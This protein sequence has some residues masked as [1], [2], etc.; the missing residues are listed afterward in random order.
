MGGG[1]GGGLGSMLNMPM[2]M[3]NGMGIMGGLNGQPGFMEGLFKQDKN[4]PLPQ[5]GLNSLWKTFGL[6]G[7][8]PAG[9]KAT[10]RDA[11]PIAGQALGT[12][13]LPGFGGGAGK[14]AGTLGA[15]MAFGKHGTDTSNYWGGGNKQMNYPTF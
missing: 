1:Q 3:I 14:A 10:A 2:G 5:T 15:M 4:N 13:F 7:I 12:V 9:F 11:A 8:L 6:E